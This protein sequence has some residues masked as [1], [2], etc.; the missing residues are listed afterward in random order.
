MEMVSA[1]RFKNNFFMCYIDL[2]LILGAMGQ[3][4]CLIHMGPCSLPL[5]SPTVGIGQGVGIYEWHGGSSSEEAKGHSAYGKQ[6]VGTWVNHG[7][8]GK[9]EKDGGLLRPLSSAEASLRMKGNGKWQE[10]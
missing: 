8:G 2:L 9:P 10:R 6:P 7:G 5:Q 1:F 4:L 3:V